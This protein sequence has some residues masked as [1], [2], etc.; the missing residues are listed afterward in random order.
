M[1]RTESTDILFNP[2][3]WKD[4]V[5]AYFRQLL[6]WGQSAT[7]FDD[8]VQGPGETLTWPYFKKVG[9]AEKPAEAASLTVDKLGDDSFT[10]S[11]VEV[12]KALAFTD[13]SFVV[14]A[15]RQQIILA[16]A[17]RNIAR[18]MAEQVDADIIAEVYTGGNYVAGFD[19]TA[20]TDLMN[21]Q[22]L[23][24]G[25]IAG[26]GDRQLEAAIC[27]MHSKQYSDMLR[28]TTT[29][30]LKADATDPMAMVTGF[31]GRLAGMAIVVSDQCPVTTD[32]ISAG[33]DSYD[34]MIF[35]PNSHGLI[36][37]KDFGEF[38]MD[39]DILARET[40]ISMTAWYSVKSFHG[41]VA[42]DDL[43]ACRIRTA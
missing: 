39:R 26:F 33:V 12:G 42:T 6:V 36:L 3:V 7:R 35:K 15:A 40:V 24:K 41:K 16:E 31:V 28:D 30:F 11:V 5:E 10:S 34:A 38:E 27:Y 20:G 2:V 32:G 18:V 22:N 8:L 25:K 1:A 37:K 14:S 29:G 19:A 13:K 23:L 17:Q 21:I 4:H 9:A 43:R